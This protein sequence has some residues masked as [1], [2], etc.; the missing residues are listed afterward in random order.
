[1]GAFSGFA[2]RLIYVQE[3][4]SSNPSTGFWFINTLK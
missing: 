3:V 2:G 4:V 1:M